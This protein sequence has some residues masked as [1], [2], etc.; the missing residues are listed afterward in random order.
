MTEHAAQL[1]KLIF[2]FSLAVLS[3][4]AAA[5]EDKVVQMKD[6]PYRRLV[7]ENTLI[8]VWEVMVPIGESSPFHE[9]KL[10]MVSVRINT[11]EVTNVPKGGLFS[12]TRDMRLESGT[13]GFSEYS[14]SP[15][16]HRISPKGPNPHRVIEFE[17]LGASG[18]ARTG[19]ASERPGITTILDNPRVLASRVVLEPEQSTEI[20]PRGNTLVV[21]IKGGV[22]RAKELKAGDVEMAWRARTAIDQE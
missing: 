3:A 19:H 18:G 2:L 11:T 22:A 20:A 4:Q 17:L 8:K 14:K 15:Y 7:L 13:V 10:D 21:V 9:H 6:D 1:W 5:Q 16:I 12:F